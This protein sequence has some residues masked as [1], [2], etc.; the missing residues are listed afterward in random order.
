MSNIFVKIT[1]GRQIQ[2][3]QIEI[4]IFDYLNKK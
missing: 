1:S 4:L 3:G 2:G